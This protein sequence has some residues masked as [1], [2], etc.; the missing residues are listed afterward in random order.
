MAVTYQIVYLPEAEAD[1][2]RILDYYVVEKDNLNFAVKLQLAILDAVD[3]VAKMP[4]AYQLETR[5][6]SRSG[7]VYRK[8]RALDYY[9]VYETRETHGDI[10]VITVYYIEAGPSFYDNDLP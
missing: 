9:V 4:S 1:I 2:G 7:K 10:V 8:V 3:K 6:K 5:C